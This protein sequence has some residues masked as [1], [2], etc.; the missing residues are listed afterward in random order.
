MARPV[1][2]G[3]CPRSGTTLLRTML[4]TYPPHLAAPLWLR[5]RYRRPVVG[6]R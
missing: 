4:N 6:A 1:F 3:G 2:V 5:L